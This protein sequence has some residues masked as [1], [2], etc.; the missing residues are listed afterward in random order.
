MMDSEKAINDGEGRS[1]RRRGVCRSVTTP[2]THSRHAFGVKH[3]NGI[4]PMFLSKKMKREL[5]IKSYSMAAEA[6]NTQ[7]DP[8]VP[9][10]A[11]AVFLGSE[12]SLDD[13]GIRR[14][15]L[16]CSIRARTV[17]GQ[18]LEVHGG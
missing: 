17:N 2:S 12:C 6:H 16:R 8:Q 13:E 18:R 3:W 5:N 15:D 14:M 1:Q 7:A 9:S 10:L 4:E 11:L